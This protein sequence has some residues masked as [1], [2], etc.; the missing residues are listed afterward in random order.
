MFNIL[1]VPEQ[2]SL[3]LW[4]QK[5]GQRYTN[6]TKNYEINSYNAKD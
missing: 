2:I 5:R 1:Q 6:C 4:E 3:T